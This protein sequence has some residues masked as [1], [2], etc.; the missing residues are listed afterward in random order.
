MSFSCFANVMSKDVNGCVDA[1][2]V[3]KLRPAPRKSKTGDWN[4]QTR[5]KQELANY[6]VKTKQVK[7]LFSSVILQLKFLRKLLQLIFLFFL[8]YYSTIR[9]LTLFTVKQ[10][11]LTLLTLQLDA[12]TYTTIE[13]YYLLHTYY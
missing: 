8:F 2:G 3:E 13:F 5:R 6:W 11:L 10:Q 7:L 4:Q 9:L 12:Y 1:W